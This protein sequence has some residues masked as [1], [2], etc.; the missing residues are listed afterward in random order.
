MRPL[1]RALERSAIRSIGKGGGRVVN[2]GS[3]RTRTAAVLLSVMLMFDG[4]A[5]PSAD[6]ATPR[7]S[8]ARLAEL[9]PAASAYPAP[10]TMEP[11]ELA[12]IC[13]RTVRGPAAELDVGAR[14]SYANAQ[15]VTVVMEEHASLARARKRFRAA[16]GQYRRT[17]DRGDV[18]YRS[19]KVRPL[20]TSLGGQRI[21]W[22]STGRIGSN[23]VSR[24][25]ASMYRV[26]KY[27]LIYEVRSFSLVDAPRI[28]R[29]P[30]RR[31]LTRIERGFDALL[32]RDAQ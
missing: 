18:T 10:A 3:R 26:G 5:A 17:C 2:V 19:Q 16:S 24:S 27:F 29:A 30:A 1:R 25:H 20:S 21:G 8:E 4:A 13:G 15:T 28:E 7:V 22:S 23:V 11:F 14:Y 9:L 32:G 31:G 12:A 6:A